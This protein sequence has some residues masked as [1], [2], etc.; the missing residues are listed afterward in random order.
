MVRTA[1]MARMALSADGNARKTDGD[2]RAL[3]S[4]APPPDGANRVLIFKMSF[5]FHEGKNAIY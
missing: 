3:S 1:D 2:D 5:S 4:H